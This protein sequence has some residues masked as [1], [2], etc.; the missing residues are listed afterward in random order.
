MGEVWG[1]TSA[2]VLTPTAAVSTALG[3]EKGVCPLELSVLR[4]EEVIN[5]SQYPVLCKGYPSLF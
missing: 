2:T 4:H 3:P 5:H 1:A